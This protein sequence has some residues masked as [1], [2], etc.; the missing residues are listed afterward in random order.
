MNEFFKNFLGF[1]WKGN[2]SNLNCAISTVSSLKNSFTFPPTTDDSFLGQIMH[3]RTSLQPVF[4]KSFCECSCLKAKT[5]RAFVIPPLGFEWWNTR[6]VLE[7]LWLLQSIQR[8]MGGWIMKTTMR[9]LAPC[10]E[11]L[12]NGS[13]CWA[14]GYVWCPLSH[15]AHVQNLTTWAW[16]SAF[17][18]ENWESEN[19]GNVQESGRHGIWTQVCLIPEWCH[20]QQCPVSSR[21]SKEVTHRRWMPIFD[22][23]A[24][25]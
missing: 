1:S 17:R 22:K 25:R 13:E 15:S 21:L 8:R 10:T 4:W 16:S 20:V 7:P 6:E 24:W 11:H 14:F 2:C 9:T 19:V 3:F 18:W 23:T 12:I 5:R